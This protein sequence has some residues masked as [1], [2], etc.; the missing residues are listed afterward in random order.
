MSATGSTRSRR[1]RPRPP[2]RV[3]AASPRTSRP[4]GASSPPS[5]RPGARASPAPRP[6]SSPRWT[7]STRSSTCWWSAPP[8]SSRRPRWRPTAEVVDDALG[9]PAADAVLDAFEHEFPDVTDA[10]D[11]VRL[12]ELLLV[13]LANENPAARPL[14]A[15]VDDARSPPPTARR[16][17][18]RSRPTRR[19]RPRSGRTARPWSSCSGRRRAPTRR[20]SPGQ[21][22]YVR[23]HWGPLLGDALDA[24]LDRLLLTLDVIAEEERGLH[25]RFGGGGFGDGPGP[26]RGA[27]P[28]RARRRAGA[29]SRATRRGCRAWS[30]RQEHPRLARP[31]VAGLRA[32]ASGRST[33][34]PTRSWTGSPGSGS[35]GCG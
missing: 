8:S 10:A 28:R 24:L 6:A 3:P 11:P 19:P 33:R 14:R 13:R 31:A 26:R 7:C 25:L 29:R 23:E 2:R 18:R 15:L 4:P 12:E 17:W 32:R 27:G 35:P 22:R 1:P 20:R 30:D 5:T 34:S 21:L 16:R 9:E